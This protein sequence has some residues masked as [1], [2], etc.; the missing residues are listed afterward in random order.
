MSPE[1]QCLSIAEI[2]GWIKCYVA[3]TDDA[4]ER[5]YTAGYV[6]GIQP[7][8]TRYRPV[9]AYLTDL[10]AMHEAEKTLTENEQEDYVCTLELILYPEGFPYPMYEPH[11]FILIHATASQRAEAF[12]RVKRPWKEEETAA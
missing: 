2:C 9:P 4:L 7:D 3:T 10:N 5:G 6:Y 8:T 11:W 12:L 1:A